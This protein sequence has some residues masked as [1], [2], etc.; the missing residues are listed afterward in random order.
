MNLRR[1]ACFSLLAYLAFAALA[2]SPA[3]PPPPPPSPPP[4]AAGQSALTHTAAEPSSGPAPV[5]AAS[6][7]ETSPPTRFGFDDSGHLRGERYTWRQATMAGLI[8]GAYGMDA[9]NVQ[10]GPSW[11][12]WDHFDIFAK[13]PAAA[14]PDDLQLMLRSLLEDR[15]HL[16]VHKGTAPM[17]AWALVADHPKVKPSPDAASGDGSAEDQGSKGSGC[18]PQPPPPGGVP[19][20]A[21]LTVN[22]KH[23]TMAEFAQTLDWMGNGVLGDDPVTDATDLKGA[24]DFT[25]EWTPPFMRRRTGDDSAG[26]TL[27]DALQRV[28]FRLERRTA[29]APVLIVDSV[30]EIPTPNAPDIAKTIP[31]LPPAAFD[32][33]VIK[34]SASGERPMAGIRGDQLNVAGF[35][36]KFFVDFAWNLNFNDGQMLANAPPWLDTAR[37]DITAKNTNAGASE[38][39]PGP[40]DIEQLRGML[41]ALLAERFEAKTHTEMRPVDTWVLRADSPRLQKANPASRTKCINGPG[42]DGK[43]PRTTNPALDRLVYCQNVTMAQFAEALS[44]L[45]PGYFNFPVADDTGLTGSFDFTLSFSSNRVSLFGSSPTPAP[46]ASGGGDSAPSASDPSGELPI[47]DAIRRQLGL[48][49]DK[50]KRPES[51]L[52]IDHIDQQPTAN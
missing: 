37:F 21:T 7:I 5:F 38:S 31:P 10:G 8:A 1:V 20:S 27:F 14:K 26:I 4:S 3:P 41:R 46:A 29:P 18:Q 6:E 48:R 45:A 32:V 43:D 30:S 13:A 33:A 9:R 39:Q 50:E 15:F 51:V 42:P 2:Q 12:E 49:M 25:V 47:Y 44:S 28:G 23:V 16:V 22:C 11:L 19:G 40:A 52:V 34:P 36:L 17:P 24:Y 35:P